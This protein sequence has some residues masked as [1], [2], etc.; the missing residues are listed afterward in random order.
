MNGPVIFDEEFS[1]EFEPG[2]DPDFIAEPDTFKMNEE[3]Y[4]E[5]DKAISG[6]KIGG[7]P[8]FMQDDQFPDGGPWNLLLQLDSTKVPFDI[9]FGDAG[10]SYMFISTDGQKGK[11]LWQCG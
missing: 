3:E 1:V 10:I 7:T 11:S 5:Y 6:N 2:E 4:E 8:G 9:N